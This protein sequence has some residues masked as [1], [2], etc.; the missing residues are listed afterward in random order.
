MLPRVAAVAEAG[1]T[2]QPRRAYPDFLNRLQGEAGLYELMGVSYGK[3][4]FQ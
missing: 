4:V 3:H 2:P 1:W